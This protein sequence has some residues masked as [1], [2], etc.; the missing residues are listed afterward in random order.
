ML[1]VMTFNIYVGGGDGDRFHRI[2]QALERCAPDILVLQECL[3]WSDQDERLGMVAEV[4]GI[5]N[6]EEHVIHGR[7]STRGSSGH[8]DVCAFSRLPFTRHE[9]LT[10]DSICHCEVEFDVNWNGGLT[11]VGA[12]FTASDQAHRTTE[13]RA[14]G[15]RLPSHVLADRPCIL[16][17]DLNSLSPRDVYP[18]DFTEQVY[19]WKGKHKFENPANSAILDGLESHGWHDALRAVH[20]EPDP[21]FTSKRSNGNGGPPILLRQDYI[22]LSS[23]LLPHL[24]DCRIEPYDEDVSDHAP[25]CATFHD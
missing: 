21:W 7:A 8:F 6:D 2:L 1:K 20:Q 16:L 19:A 3:N 15:E 11:V 4:L 5:P 17:G 23:P 12:H 22:L 25:V 13:A 24:A 18:E 10:G 9:V 14:L